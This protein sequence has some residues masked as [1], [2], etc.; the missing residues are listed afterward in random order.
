MLLKSEIILH[1]KKRDKIQRLNS[2]GVKDFKLSE[3]PETE[4]GFVLSQV[5]DYQTIYLELK[6]DFNRESEYRKI[7]ASK[8]P[9]QNGKN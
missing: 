5:Y 4:M 9:I 6:K 1:K 8:K 2:F 7:L 3:I